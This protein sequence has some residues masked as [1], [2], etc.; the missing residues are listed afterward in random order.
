MLGLFGASRAV[1]PRAYR[2]GRAD[3]EPACAP[4]LG[5]RL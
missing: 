1:K 2:T 5:Y 3:G 4:S